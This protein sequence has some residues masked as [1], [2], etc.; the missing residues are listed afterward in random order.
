MFVRCNGYD[1]LNQ[2]PCVATAKIFLISI[3]YILFLVLGRKP[4]LSFFFSPAQSAISLHSACFYLT[5]WSRGLAHTSSTSRRWCRAHTM[6]ELILPIK[7][8]RI[9]LDLLKLFRTFDSLDLLFSIFSKIGAK[10][11]GI[12]TVEEASR[13]AIIGNG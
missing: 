12:K 8:G 3:R 2:C 1:V 7:S 13:P 5:Q 11:L 6:L 10:K 9:F 4:I